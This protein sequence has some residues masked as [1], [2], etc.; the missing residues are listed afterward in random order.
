MASNGPGVANL[1]PGLVVEQADG[2]RV[3][4]ITSARR[5]SIMYPDRGGSYQCFDQSG[6][7]GKIGKWSTAVSS[8]DPCS[9][10]GAQG[11]AQELGG[12][13]RRGARRCAGEHHERQNSRAD[14]G[15]LAPHQ[16]RNAVPPAPTSEQVKQAA[17]LLIAAG[18]PMNP[19]RQRHHSLQR[20]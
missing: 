5:P 3:L 12:A 9:G 13:A 2:N 17:D 11:A 18:A 19:R 6:V 7:I 4:A 8:F 16:Y 1:L 15:L 20:L 14:I 10:T